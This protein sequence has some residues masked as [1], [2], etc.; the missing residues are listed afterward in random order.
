MNRLETT[1]ELRDRA[2]TLY[3]NWLCVLTRM[4]RNYIF[5]AHILHS[6]SFY[7]LVNHDSNREKDGIRLRATWLDLMDEEADALGV[8]RPL[9]PPDSLDGPCSVFEMMIALAMRLESDIMQND[10]I[11]PRGAMWFWAMLE[12]LGLSNL[13]DR[14]PINEN[15]VRTV[16]QNMLDRNYDRY[17]V[18]GLFP[19]RN[20]SEDQSQVELW[21]QAQAWLQENYTQ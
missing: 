19:I 8:G 18:G 11:G 15:A 17:G 14:H 5:L 20:P 3:F 9:Y 13:D 16:V 1:E 4:D 2:K 12:N 21:R 10:T 7:S 6:M